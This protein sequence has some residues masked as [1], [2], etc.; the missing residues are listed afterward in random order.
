MNDNTMDDDSVK[1]LSHSISMGICKDE[2]WMKDTVGYLV[3][4]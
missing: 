2:R 1:C 3:T 4:N